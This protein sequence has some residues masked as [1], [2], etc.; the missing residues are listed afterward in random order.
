MRFCN[1]LIKT[2]L[3]ILFII[4]FY[5]IYC[6]LICFALFY[7]FLFVCLLFKYRKI[8]R[9]Q[10]KKSFNLPEPEEVQTR[11][12]TAEMKKQLASALKNKIGK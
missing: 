9:E 7:L 2:E 10:Y 6:I 4:C 5:F 11:L 1:L 12:K 8:S 3:G